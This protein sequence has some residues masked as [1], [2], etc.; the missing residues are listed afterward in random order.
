MTS[1]C[2][3]EMSLLV[4]CPPLN[5]SSPGN[6][7][8]LSVPVSNSNLPNSKWQLTLTRKQQSLL[9]SAVWI[10]GSHQEQCNA[11]NNYNGYNC[12]GSKTVYKYPPQ[13]ISMHFIHHNRGIISKTV[14][15]SH[16]QNTSQNSCQ[17]EVPADKALR[18]RMYEFEIVFSTSSTLSR[19]F[20]IPLSVA[21]DEVDE[22]T[23]ITAGPTQAI[24]KTLLADRHSVDVQFIFTSDKNCPNIG[25]WAHRSILSRYKS[26]E[27]LIVKSLEKQNVKK[28]NV[29]PLTI[30]LN[31]F[32]LVT[33]ACLVYYFYTGTIK[34]SI[35]ATQFALS[36]HDETVIVVKDQKTGQTKEHL[37]WNPL[38]TDSSWKLKDVTWVDLLFISEYFSIKELRDECVTETIASIKDS[39]V[40]ELLFEVG[41]YFEKVKDACL[42]YLADNMESMCD[43]GKD[44]F[45]KYHDHEDCHKLMLDTMRYKSIPAARRMNTLSYAVRK[46]AIT[47]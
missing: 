42:V 2:V 1:T 35:D 38:N 15:P 10:A 47:N 13:F 37:S 5:T 16:F 27:D 21:E 39:N 26:L 40:V 29:G 17:L 36:Q 31:S 18:G 6:T 7:T 45:E 11:Y 33:F 30:H 32:S 46:L 19:T 44:P 28:D 14:A 3:E 9:I 12:K 23:A 8:T 24:M 25:F 41:I 34:R 43:E 20:R 4:S 22:S